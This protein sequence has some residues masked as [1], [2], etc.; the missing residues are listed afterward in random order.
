ML[1]LRLLA[2]PT[3][4]ATCQSFLSFSMVRSHKRTRNS[5]PP[6]LSDT[7]V[8]KWTEDNTNSENSKMFEQRF[9]IENKTNE[10]VRGS[11]IPS[12]NT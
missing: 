3:S 12:I 5:L 4:P 6:P 8:T 1:I 9:D 11:F 10:E 7:E 2:M